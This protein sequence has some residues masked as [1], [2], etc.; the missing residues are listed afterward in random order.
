[1]DYKVSVQRVAESEGANLK[2]FASVTFEDSFKVT[3]IKVYQGKNGPFVA[4]PNYNTHKVD[5]D[6]RPVYEDLCHPVTKEFREDLN[7]NILQCYRDNLE[8][9]QNYERTCSY[10]EEGISV[11]ANITPYTKEGRDIQGIGRI[12]L[13]D[14]FAVKNVVV[15][16]SDKGSWVSMPSVRNRSDFQDVCY[17]V[18]KD[19]R[20]EMNGKVLGA[21]EDA[22]GK[23]M[24][25]PAK[26]KEAEPAAQKPKKQEH[27]R[28]R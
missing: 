8:D 13:N 7:G 12:V 26:A 18:T 4:M 27:K 2:A 16:G 3:G 21:L 25:A 17:P 1:M 14:C 10:G 23:D 19:F 24:D 6:N 9:H 15:H 5:R 28:G 11:K 22:R 20:M